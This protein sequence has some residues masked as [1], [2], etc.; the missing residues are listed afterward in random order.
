MEYLT[1]NQTQRFLVVILLSIVKSTV[2]H[3]YESI[4]LVWQG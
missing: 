4:V 3:I 2:S 1:L